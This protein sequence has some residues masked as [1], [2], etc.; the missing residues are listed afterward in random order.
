MKK[1]F[2]MFAAAMF[3]L[4]LA[5]PA[6]YAIG[7]EMPME[8]LLFM[9]IPSVFTASKKAESINKA[10][11]V[12]YV[13]TAEE[14]KRSGARSLADVLRR[15]PGFKISARETSLLGTRGFTSDQN[16]K[17][18]FLID[19]APMTNIMQDGS[20][21]YIDMPNMN[22]V[23]KI[24]IVKGPG[25]TL[26]GS[27]ASLG[28]I[29][30][31]TKKGEDVDGTKVTVDYSSN[32]NQQVGNLLYG[33]KTDTGDILFSFTY[34]NSDGFST[35]PDWNTVW[36]WGGEAVSSNVNPWYGAGSNSRGA[37]LRDFQPSWEAYAKVAVDDEWT[38]KSRASYE[39][40]NYMWGGN[41]DAVYQDIDF[42]HFYTEIEKVK[43]LSDDSELTEKVNVHTMSYDRGIRMDCKDP[44][45]KIDL[46][47]KT[48]MGI[49]LESILT[50]TLW[51]K[52]DI[53]AGLKS[54]SVQYGPSTR[55]NYFAG[56]ASTTLNGA[57]YGGYQYVYVTDA[58]LDNTLGAYLEDSFS[59]TD[60]LTLVA[61]VSYEYNDKREA[62][63][64]TMP[65]GAIIYDF[66][67]QLSAKCAYNTGYE[68]PPIDKKFH[69]HFGHVEKSE[70]IEESDLQVSFNS[71]KTRVSVT[72]FVYKITN[73]FTWIDESATGGPQGH[74]NSGEAK[75]SGGE[76][77]ARHNLSS[78]LALYCNYTYADTKINDVIPNGDP[79]QIYN[80]GSDYYLNKD[81]SLNVNLNGWA[82]M[83]YG[84]EMKWTGETSGIL[85][86]TL[87]MDNVMGK[88][89]TVTIYGKNVLDNRTVPVG[90]TG[91]PGF[92][93][94]Q[95]A[96][97]GAKVA[98]KF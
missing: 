76:L 46:E 5:V 49:A 45:A 90:M 1:I 60:K 55:Q 70:N 71:E 87:V 94:E 24:E 47:Q 75:S 84:T 53:V 19:G 3:V 29:N 26:W 81:I 72:G 91:W 39:R 74:G 8:Q 59:A 14:I 51:D 66:T 92:T 44:L 48:E 25:S 12:V 67:D 54:Q 56:S 98:Y 6:L 16:D 4:G 36:L 57:Y 96:S 15:V 30:I 79:K 43:K 42:K 82:D 22:M 50:K 95:S 63:G 10:P 18:V 97:A 93:Y 69:K 73:Y 7:D 86:A 2:S 88:P 62:G 32:D 61:G 85:D 68:R 83:Y 11:S 17:Y 65:R 35:D 13:V 37:K 78:S 77:E 58:G 38:V 64:Q 21:G 40:M 41:Y 31:F 9:E 89:M 33:K 28:I 80:I 23:E 20:W 52:H 34:T 27:D